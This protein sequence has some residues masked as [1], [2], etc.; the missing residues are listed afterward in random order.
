MSAAKK[1]YSVRFARNVRLSIE[2]HHT[3]GP[4]A[5]QGARAVPAVQYTWAVPTL[6]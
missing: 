5:G 3:A 6:P 4:E 1:T 2:Q